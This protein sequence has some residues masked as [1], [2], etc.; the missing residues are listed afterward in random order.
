MRP[1]AARP[2]SAF[3]TSQGPT[4]AHDDGAITVRLVRYRDGSTSLVYIANALPWVLR[5]RH[6]VAEDVD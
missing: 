1:G 4:G 6:L 3:F 2:D 5:R